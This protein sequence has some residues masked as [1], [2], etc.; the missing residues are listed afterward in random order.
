M[1]IEKLL[2]PV[3]TESPCGPDLEYDPDFHKLSEALESPQERIVGDVPEKE[4]NW[5]EITSRAETLCL[6]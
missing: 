2:K 4:P 3:S 6:R 5:N 1:E